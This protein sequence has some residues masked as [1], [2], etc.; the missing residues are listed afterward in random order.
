MMPKDGPLRYH[1]F[2]GD[3]RRQACEGE[4]KEQTEIGELGFGG[5]TDTKSGRVSRRKGEPTDSAGARRSIK[6]KIGKYPLGLTI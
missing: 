4:R 2:S 5:I 6:T 3:C 1:Y